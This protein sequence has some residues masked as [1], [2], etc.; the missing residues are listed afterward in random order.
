MQFYPSSPR[1]T[2]GS[3]EGFT[4]DEQTRV[5]Q[6]QIRQRRRWIQPPIASDETVQTSARLEELPAP[7]KG[8][9]VLLKPENLTRNFAVVG[10]LALMVLAINHSGREENISVFSALKSEM[11]ATWD[12]D[13]GKLSFVSEL[14]PPEIR[15]V[16]NPSPAANV[17]AP[18]SGQVVHAWSLQEPYLEFQCS[19]TDVCSSGAGEVMSIAHGLNEERIIRI[20]HTDGSETLYGNLKECFVDVGSIVN[21]GDII[22]SLLPGYPLAFELRVDGRSVD[23]VPCMAQ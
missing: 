4:L 6:I 2:L 3:E 23:P 5:N 10:C 7:D 22:G 11:T 8:W 13:I 20:R 15:E 14:L 21:G 18:V 19:M 12:N 1:H 16:W 17:M 9:R